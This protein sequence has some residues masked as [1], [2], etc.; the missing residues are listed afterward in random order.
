MSG[1]PDSVI[2]VMNLSWEI[3]ERGTDWRVEIDNNQSIA[4]RH[5][6][7]RI[8][9]SKGGR[10]QGRASTAG[11]R[12]RTGKLRATYLSCMHMFLREARATA[13]RSRPQSVRF[14]CAFG[15]AG[16]G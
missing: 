10:R 8:R 4:K 12:S 6:Q 15:R 11:Q 3:L 2:P 9:R 7:F 5:K 14:T 1:R 16:A 13:L